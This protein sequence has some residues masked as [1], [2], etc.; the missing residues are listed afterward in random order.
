L[1]PTTGEPYNRRSIAIPNMR[2]RI[3]PRALQQVAAV[4]R[5]GLPL[6]Q[7]SGPAGSDSG[8]M[9][10]WPHA[11]EVPP[12]IRLL[13]PAAKL[14]GVENRIDV[15]QYLAGGTSVE[16]RLEIIEPLRR[17]LQGMSGSVGQGGQKMSEQLF[18]VHSA[19]FT[20]ISELPASP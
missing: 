5:P 14:R 19:S 20:T 2:E 12:H 9:S 3:E 10:R 7:S 1:A 16:P 18:G 11:R 13:A 6:F 17:F 4:R 15:I 8:E